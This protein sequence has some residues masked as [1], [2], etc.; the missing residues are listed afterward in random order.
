[1]AVLE[2]DKLINAFP[3]NSLTIAAHYFKGEAYAVMQDWK[4]AL[5]SY[6]K[7]Y[8]LEVD[9]KYSAKALIN[10]GI[11]LGKM[12]NVFQRSNLEGKLLNLVTELNQNEELETDCY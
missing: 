4:S 10:V 2:F 8:E 1:L 5:K 7:S 9:G 6:L 3:S 12:G 11:S